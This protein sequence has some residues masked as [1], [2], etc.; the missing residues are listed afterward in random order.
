MTTVCVNKLV[1]LHVFKTSEKQIHQKHSKVLI[2]ISLYVQRTGIK[3]KKKTLKLPK[4]MIKI[5]WQGEVG[6]VYK[7]DLLSPRLAIGKRNSQ[8]IKTCLAIFHFL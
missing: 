1:I 2:F 5:K 6:G 7:V 4:R 8:S 3:Q